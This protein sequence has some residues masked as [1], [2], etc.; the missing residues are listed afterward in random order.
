MNVLFI[1]TDQHRR[2]TLSCYGNTDTDTPNL[3]RLAREGVVFDNAY[4]TCAVCSPARASI[5]TGLYPFKHGMQTNIFMHGCMIHELADSPKLLSRRLYTAGVTPAFT[6][7]WHLG[8]GKPTRDQYPD[9]DPGFD[10]NRDSVELPEAYKGVTSL[11]STV[12]FVG[13]DFPGHG[14][15]GH[16]YPQ[17]KEYLKKQGLELK[18]IDMGHNRFE[19]TSGDEATVD[20]FLTNRTI[21]LVD[22]VST[23]GK[24][25]FMMLNYWG[26]HE[27]YYVPTRFLEP[28]RNKVYQPWPSF[29][30]DQTSKPT[31]HNAMR[32]TRPWTHWQ[33]ELRYYHA[34]INYLDHEIGRVFQHLE[35]KGL[36]DDTLI[37]FSADHGDAGG[38]HA[39]TQ[40]KSI[41]NYETTNAIPLIIRD[42]NGR[43][44]ERENRFANLT[45]LYAT[46]L[47]TAGDPAPNDRHG[48]SLL[49]L[50]RGEMTADWPDCAVTEGSG[51]QHLLVSQRAIRWSQFKYVFNGGDLEELYNL[52]N[53]P[54]EMCNLAGEE[55]SADLL[56]EGRT[57]LFEWLNNN[58]DHLAGQFKRLLLNQGIALN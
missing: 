35:K 7:K 46:I 53:D 52:E 50:L 17:Y 27:P 41:H 23:Q 10:S 45:D 11:P 55:Q 32:D 1:L 39:G 44:G 14:G 2:D 36:M 49:P 57:K 37:I 18:A 5:H 22:D 34:Y 19:V 28:Y 9:S 13:D 12:G 6:G 8:Y 40:N 43:T 26:P 15:G 16:S 56:M 30:E 54:H 21:E 31:I 48:R 3:D 47:D 29:E 51:I 24:P 4:T 42:P 38:T 58:G 20:H 33:E 25:F